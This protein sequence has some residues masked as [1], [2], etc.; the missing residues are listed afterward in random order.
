MT[1]SPRLTLTRIALR[2]F[3]NGDAELL[4]ALHRDVD[5]ARVVPSGA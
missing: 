2:S 1:V 3:T 4:F 5:V